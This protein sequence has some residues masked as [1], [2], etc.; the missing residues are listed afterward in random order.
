MMLLCLIAAA[1]YESKAR[2]STDGTCV[3]PSGD[4]EALS[5]VYKMQVMSDLTT[6]AFEA[7]NE[8]A[9]IAPCDP[10]DDCDYPTDPSGG[11]GWVC[12]SMGNGYY[13]CCRALPQGGV[14]CV[15]YWWG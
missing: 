13:R 6:R 5:F 12:Q 15:N 9:S 4:I 2:Y 3:S 8:F 14:E 11:G 1:N 7:K 10:E